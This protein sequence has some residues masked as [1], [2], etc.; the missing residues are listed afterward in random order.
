MFESELP[1]PQQAREMS[2]E[3]CNDAAGGAHANYAEACND[4][5]LAVHAAPL[6]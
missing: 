6:G 4:A 2:A 5:A 1:I 3:A